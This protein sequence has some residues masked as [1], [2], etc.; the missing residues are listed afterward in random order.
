MLKDPIES[1]GRCSALHRRIRIGLVLYAPGQDGFSGH[2]R[3]VSRS[4]LGFPSGTRPGRKLFEVSKHTKQYATFFTLEAESGNLIES[5]K[6]GLNEF[7]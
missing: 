3:L 6:R 5:R 1:Y 7:G 4:F 2:G